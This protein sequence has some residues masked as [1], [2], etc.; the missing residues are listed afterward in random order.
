[1]SIIIQKQTTEQELYQQSITEQSEFTEIFS[2]LDQIRS[3]QIPENFKSKAKSIS[4][5]N[6]R[7]ENN[8]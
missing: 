2:F 7:F 3:F 1:M 5:S 8:S 4:F 6:L